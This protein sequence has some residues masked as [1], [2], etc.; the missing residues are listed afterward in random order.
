MTRPTGIFSGVLSGLSR[1]LVAVWL[2]VAVIALGVTGACS[3]SQDQGTA[4]DLP[5]PVDPAEG[6][7]GKQACQAYV[8]QL[9]ACA[10][11]RPDDAELAE[12]CRMAPAKLSSLAAVLEVNRTSQDLT[13]IVSTE[14][15]A[16][17]IMS[18]CIEEQSRLLGKG[19]RPP[20]A[21]P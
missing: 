4:Q 18:S 14:R 10:E 6:E 8:A 2:V 3:K 11:S 1:G 17:K 9:C 13:E 12:S 21:K 15:T 19:C 7:R 20:A 16:R 5:E